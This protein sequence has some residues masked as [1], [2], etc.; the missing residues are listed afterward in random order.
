VSSNDAERD[1]VRLDETA[2]DGGA[3]ALTA[4]RTLCLLTGYGLV[5]LFGYVLFDVYRTDFGPTDTGAGVGL[6]WFFSSVLLY[7]G[8]TLV[9]VGLSLPGAPLLGRFSPRRNPV[10]RR[11]IAI[12]VG[13]L[14]TTP[15]LVLLSTGIGATWT[16][17]ALLPFSGVGAVIVAAGVLW[18]AVDAVR[19]VRVSS[20]CG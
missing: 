17:A 13:L 12:G 1:D 20:R 3:D 14:G 9:G 16:L 11:A 4:I 18:I 15:L 7:V 5:A 8:V 19:D 10:R 2:V 6:A